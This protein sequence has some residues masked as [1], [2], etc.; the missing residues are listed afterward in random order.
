MVD[1]GLCKAGAVHH[2]DVYLPQQGQH[3]EKHLISQ[4]IPIQHVLQILLVKEMSW[5]TTISGVSSP[6][7]LFMLLQ[8][9]NPAPNHLHHHLPPEIVIQVQ[10]NLQ[11]QV[12]WN[13]YT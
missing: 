4:G 11:V 2:H 3:S 1:P 5:V 12:T 6:Q 7:V 9:K 8:Q 10:W 13:M